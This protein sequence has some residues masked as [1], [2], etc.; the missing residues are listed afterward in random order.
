[1]HYWDASA[2]VPLCFDEGKTARARSLARA[3]GI[4]TWFL[5]PVEVASAVERRFREGALEAEGRSLALRTLGDLAASWIEV[6]AATRVRERALRVLATHSLR[7]ADAL[8]LAAAL[9]ATEDR[10]NGSHFVCDDHRLRDAATREG[11]QAV[12]L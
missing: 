8:Q 4:V 12:D 10:P 9:V 5:S 6:T 11:F 1:M 7:A 2:L 3:Q